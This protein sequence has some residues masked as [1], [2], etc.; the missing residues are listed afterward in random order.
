MR[1]AT[2]RWARAVLA[3]GALG[4]VAAPSAWAGATLPTASQITAPAPNDRPFTAATAQ[5]GLAAAGYREEEWRVTL[6]NP[7]VY[8]LSTPG[9]LDVTASGAPASP[10]GAYRSRILVRAPQNPANFNGRVVV[11]VL[12]ATTGVDLDILWQQS[13]EYFE[14]TGTIYVGIA[15]QP[16]TLLS[17]TTGPPSGPSRLAGRYSGQ[18]LN[19]ATPAALANVSN[20]TLAAAAQRDPSLAWDLIGQV[21]RLA[22]SASGPFAGYNVQQVLATGWSQS[23]T[24]LTTYVNAIH[25]LH[26]VYDGFLIGARGTGATTLQF[27]ATPNPALVLNQPAQTT[28]NG[29]GT[30]VVNLQTETDSK[31]SIVRRADADAPSDR[32]RLYEVPGSAHNDEWAAIQAVDIITRD[33]FQSTPPGCFWTG[34]DKITSNPVRYVVNAAFDGL[35]AW[36]GGGAAPPS[37][38]RIT[39]ADGAGNGVAIGSLP[40]P[41]YPANTPGVIPGGVD[42]ISRD[43]Q[44]NALG[45]VRTPFVDVASRAY[46]PIS[47]GPSA[48]FCTLT[49]RETPLTASAATS[50]HP[51]W[52]AFTAAYDAA[53]ASAQSAG[54][55][56]AGDRAQ[57]RRL[58]LQTYT[59]K[60]DDPTVPAG[61]SPS[62]TG[63]FT[64]SWSGPDPAD[65]ANFTT[66]GYN[67]QRRDADEA[68]WSDLTTAG[69]LA[70]RSITFA[71]PT[72]EPEGT[73]RYRTRVRAVQVP[74]QHA[75]N[76][77][78]TLSSDWAESAPV[79]IDR[80]APGPPTAAVDRPADYTGGGGWWKT[81]ATVSFAGSGDPDLADG[82]AG[83]GVDP[84][85]I[86][87]PQTRSTSGTLNAS[88]TVKDNAGNESGPGGTQVQVDATAPTLTLVACPAQV[89]IGSAASAA[90]TAAD[91]E[92]GL[93][94]PA[95]GSASIDTST[96][97]TRSTTFTSTDNV[98]LTTMRT[99]TTSVV[100][101]YGGIQQPVN[102]DGTSI[103]KLGSTVPVK[104]RIGDAGGS[105]VSS[106]IARLEL[107]KLTNSVEGTVLEATTNGNANSGNFFRLS[108]PGEYIY[109]LST[110]PLSTG[111]W[112][113]RISLDD[114]TTYTTRIS[115]R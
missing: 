61:T 54:F 7:D 26:Q 3:A 6:N 53:A 45:G 110:K 98:G 8:S 23:A 13:Y 34:T 75:F 85:T 84:A 62:R 109:N 92:S 115:L 114:G 104:I 4:L 71:G 67:V 87:A 73:V 97:G 96:I 30:P 51:N 40:S 50:L 82:S 25:P 59:V 70:Q 14:R 28:L 86:P 5:S 29:R 100:Y 11:E 48:A 37:S 77:P 39:A 81:T 10:F 1:R 88:G 32:F 95:A 47:F 24:Y 36:A 65:P 16:L 31:A 49:G 89:P 80:T 91:E 69:G 38:P 57:A 33:T 103:F 108:G 94:S 68:D 17:A 105:A 35:G 107:V 111:T 9:T 43:A 106:A 12:N 112:A 21:G 15:A 56:L 99:C 52:S 64:A 102:A 90:F 79:K 63:E 72:A 18:G 83:S 58:A 93:A 22:R 42:G 20:P 19:L 76:V 44:G 27:S 113:L 46:K 41:P 101:V 74:R 55:L 78:I 66:V 2:R 60:P